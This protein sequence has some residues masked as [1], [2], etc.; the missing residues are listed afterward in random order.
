MTGI[1][2]LTRGVRA[3]WRQRAQPILPWALALGLPVAVA[4]AFI[5]ARGHIAPADVVLVLVV[6]VLGA[7]L[8]GGRT[9]GA[10]AA[11]SAALAFD[12]FQTRPYYSLRVD[13]AQDIETVL[14]LL[15][16]GLAI[17]DLVTRR[18]R[19]RAAAASSGAEIQRLHRLTQLAAGGETPGR[20][21]YLVRNE[22]IETVGLEDCE[23]QRPPFVDA[24]PRLGHG[25]IMIPPQVGL[26]EQD[27][28]A[29]RRVELPVWG[30]GLEVG[31]FVLTLSAPG[32]GIDVS[33]D[34]RR[35]AVA[36]ADQLGV[37][38][39]AHER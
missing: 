38:L 2:P 3:G 12:F 15:L 27:P 31:R 26:V 17:G 18:R 39:L 1:Q 20:L 19:D 16:V 4:A 7:A 9:T 23:F 6:V 24:M 14:L 34:V 22:L 37:I 29:Y 36:L 35:A 13:S 33:P 30:E 8:L 11:V 28:D 21:I 5:P 32:T 10:V 25:G